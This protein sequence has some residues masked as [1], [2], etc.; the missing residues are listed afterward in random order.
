M[1]YLYEN[2]Y[3]C[4]YTEYMKGI[5]YNRSKRKYTNTSNKY[6]LELMFD[7][8]LLE[9]RAKLKAMAYDVILLFEYIKAPLP[10]TLP[11]GISDIIYSYYNSLQPFVRELQDWF[12]DDFY[13]QNYNDNQYE[14][15]RSL[16]IEF[17]DVDEYFPDTCINKLIQ[18][19]YFKSHQ[20]VFCIDGIPRHVEIKSITRLLK[21]SKRKKYR[22]KS[23]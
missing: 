6:V 7:K 10:P 8:T 18:T 12:G 21:Y 19:D 13:T 9:E 3:R 5:K 22:M 4:C 1:I 14:A 20:V 15:Q 23:I 16:I 11:S 2:R 17:V